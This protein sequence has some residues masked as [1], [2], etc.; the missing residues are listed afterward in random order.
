MSSTARAMIAACGR[1]GAVLAFACILSCAAG[2][3][4]AEE[5]AG[6]P[7]PLP[8]DVVL[9]LPCGQV[10]ALR[11][12]NTQEA[13]SD[14]SRLLDDRRVLLG[15]PSV[16]T[17][18][19]DYNRQDF[20]AGH[21]VDGSARFFLIGKYEVTRAQYASLMT[22][23]CAASESDA[24]TPISRIS[25]YDAVE[26]TRRLTRYV[27]S[28]GAEALSAA[29]GRDDAYFRLPTEA[30]WEYAA[31]GG[32]SV[33]T[34]DF[35]AERYPMAGNPEA[36]IW[37]N[38][39][40]SS[41]GQLQEIAIFDPNPL[42]LHDVYGNVAEML[43]DPFR[44][45]KAGRMHGLAGGFVAKGGSF[46]SPLNEVTSAA[47]REHGYFDASGA[48]EFAANDIGLRV[49]LA[50][51]TLAG[52]HDAAAAQQE[53]QRAA[54]ARLLEGE[55]PVEQLSA[56]QE[57]LTDLQLSGDIDAIKQ[58][59]R[60]L[61]SGRNDAQFRLLDGLLLSSGRMIQELTIRQVNIRGRQEL[62][63]QNLVNAQ[64]RE[65]IAR[66][67]QQDEREIRE[68][69]IFY[70]DL[71]VRI[72][73]EFREQEIADRTGVVIGELIQRGFRETDPLV[74]AIALGGKIAARL[75]GGETGYQRS[76]ILR[77]I[78]EETPDP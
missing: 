55:N 18:Y 10:L 48:D 42:G 50:S 47:R 49:L 52:R 33:S 8:D 21:F 71:A 65:Q 31:R 45:N 34:A 67:R 6:N 28:N 69:N 78:L 26:F 14:S 61:L 62:I 35:Q 27:R 70:H 41:G 51:A 76:E 66:S 56:L 59:I 30:E 5:P 3:V 38:A 4:S 17:A 19:F 64:E 11:H 53:W 68:L 20:I 23:G 22:D 25:W 15:R 32:L 7:V 58:S 73:N 9:T 29:T 43:L 75:A 63:D 37:M 74:R 1:A 57:G 44:L 39:P 24:R 2:Q 72:S 36:S 60:A 16:D 13:I 12:V 77:I 54:Q 40:L 46:L